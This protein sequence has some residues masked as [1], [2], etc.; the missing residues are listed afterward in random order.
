M[1]GDPAVAALLPGL[2]V[3]TEQAR[4]KGFEEPVDFL[5]ISFGREAAENS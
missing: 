1:A 4:L 2:A 5:R 3:N